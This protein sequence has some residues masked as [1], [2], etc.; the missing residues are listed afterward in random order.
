MVLQQLDAVEKAITS[1]IKKPGAQVADSEFGGLSNFP[2]L[3]VK[4]MVEY[5]YFFDVIKFH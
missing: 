3:L 2:R 4:L 5:E 1:R